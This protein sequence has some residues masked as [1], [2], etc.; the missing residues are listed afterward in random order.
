[1]FGSRKRL[2]TARKV[3]FWS[4]LPREILMSSP[5]GS[6]KEY[7]RERSGEIQ[8]QLMWL[9]EYTWLHNL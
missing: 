7:G 6:F 2:L 4:R 5:Q 8:T 3:K 1:M 9:L